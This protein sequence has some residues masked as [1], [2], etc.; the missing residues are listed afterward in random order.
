MRKGIGFESYNDDNER[1]VR[2]NQG[3]LGEKDKVNK[4]LEQMT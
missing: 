3:L 2:F 1:V 4:E